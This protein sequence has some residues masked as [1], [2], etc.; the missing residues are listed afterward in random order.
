MKPRGAIL[1]SVFLALTSTHPS[2]AVAGDKKYQEAEVLLAKAREASDIRCEGC[3]PF[4]LTAQ[5]REFGEKYQ[6]I[7]GTY[8]EGTCVLNWAS[9][10]KWREEY[11][12]GD[13]SEVQLGLG[14]WIHAKRSTLYRPWEPGA[15][16]GHLDIGE[17]LG[18]LVKAKVRDLSER[19]LAK[20]SAVCAQ[21]QGTNTSPDVQTLC[22][23]REGGFL[24]ERQEQDNVW[25]Y[26]QYGS[27]AGKEYPRRLAFYTKGQLTLEVRVKELVASPA[28]PPSLFEPLTGPDVHT[29]CR[30]PELP[31][32]IRHDMPSLPDDLLG[33]YVLE[34]E[35]SVGTDG[36]VH[37]MVVSPSAN[38][39]I[40]QLFVKSASKWRYTPAKCM[41]KAY[42]LHLVQETVIE[43]HH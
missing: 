19:Q 18:G 9:A 24:T 38:P 36:K 22:F 21:Y 28:W 23:L 25:R 11:T 29:S 6:L 20:G 30:D 3:P 37:N 1:I 34:F 7:E 32:P 5:I 41:G 35:F 14:G 31:T 10:D 2:V 4:R 42:E 8:N 43:H 26:E 40:A 39:R 12:L 16:A 33:H 13:Y 17:S 15:L 27:F